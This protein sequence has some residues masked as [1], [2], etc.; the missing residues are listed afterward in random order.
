[1]LFKVTDTGMGIKEK[2]RVR[3]FDPFHQADMSTTKKAEG[4]GLGL[5]ITKNLL[6]KMGSTLRF[7]STYGEGSTFYFELMVPC[8]KEEADNLKQ[9]DE[10]LA[11]EEQTFKD[12]KVL[13]AEDNPVNLN[14]I[15]TALAMFSKDMEVISAKN[16][17]EA[18]E[19]YRKHKV[20]LILM[21]IV[22]P[23]IDGYQATAMIR[24][25]DEKVPI[26]A[27]TAKALKE[28]KED[29]LAAGMNDYIAKPVSL[30]LL[31]E[32][33]KKHLCH[34]RGTV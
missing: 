7:N 24:S 5:A 19:Q 33:L 10:R 30:D 12:K 29:C 13:I 15:Q 2:D 22:M 6:E 11:A 27:M 23:K 14:Y 32:I 4:A 25:L 17:K 34:Q 20:D 26:V 9:K 3:I 21:D 1:M 8:G 31:K 16:G 28:D 18:Y